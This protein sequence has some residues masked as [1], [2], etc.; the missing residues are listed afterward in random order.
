MLI[1][2]SSR[3]DKRFQAIFPDKT[4]INF[5]LKSGNTYIDHAD[6][7][8]RE[9]YIKRHAPNEDWTKINPGSLSRYILWGSS[10]NIDKNFYDYKKKFNV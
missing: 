8:K 7:K 2:P 9:N 6:K 1:R 10:S 4:I 5:G 3:K